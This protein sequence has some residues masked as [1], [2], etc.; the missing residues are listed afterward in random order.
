ME[1]DIM[2]E[3]LYAQL[4]MAEV[5]KKEAEEKK[6]QEIKKKAEQDRL[7]VLKWQNDQNSNRR[8]T[9]QRMAQQEK[10]MLNDQWQLEDEAEKQ[11]QTQ[12]FLINKERNLELIRHN[13]LEKEIMEA[14]AN[15]ERQRD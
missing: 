1:A 9:E 6:G 11:R 12:Q 4:A 7:D 8:D 15:K 10:N 13:A 5:K 14:E 3:N 2:E